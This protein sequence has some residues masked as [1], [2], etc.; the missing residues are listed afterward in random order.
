MLLATAVAASSAAQAQQQSAESTPVDAASVEV[1][2]VVVTGTFIRD[3]NVYS[4]SQITTVG[5]E[6]IAD[7]GITRVEDYLNDLPQV[8]PGQSITASNGSTGTAT[9]NLRNLGAQ[10]TLV[11]SGSETYRNP[12]HSTGAEFRVSET[13]YATVRSRGIPLCGTAR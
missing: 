4:S 8:S 10:R 1:E 6:D 9:V 11:C 2:E 12:S 13:P 7:R 5:I 3:R